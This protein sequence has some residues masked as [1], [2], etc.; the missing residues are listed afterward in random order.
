MTSQDVI[1]LR[2]A[3]QLYGIPGAA[4]IEN[5]DDYRGD[6][7]DD[8]QHELD[9]E[10]LGAEAG[11]G[12]SLLQRYNCL[13]SQHWLCK[14]PDAPISLKGDDGLD[15]CIGWSGD[16]LIDY[17]G[18]VALGI[19][20]FAEDAF[21]ADEDGLEGDD[22]FYRLAADALVNGIPQTELIALGWD[23][24]KAVKKAVRTVSKPLGKVVRTVTRPVTKVA[25]VVTKPVSRVVKTVTKP[26]A[27][28]VGKVT[29]KVLPKSIRNLGNAVI[30]SAIATTNPAN[31]LNPAKVMRDQIAVAKAAVPVA[32]QL[33][34]SPIVKTVAGGAAIVFP[35]VGVPAAA[36]LATASAI[37][38]AVDSKAP[39]VR[40]AAEKVL[41][42][43][44]KVI[45]GGKGAPPNSKAA[46]DAKGAEVAMAQIAQA[47]KAQM[48]TRISTPS[49]P[50]ARRLIHEV[51]P[52]GR[53]TRIVA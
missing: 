20:I 22:D 12:S 23:P 35:P 3:M 15:G 25:G 5:L 50:G 4:S 41:A 44:M 7:Q 49:T 31:M 26:V 40:A 16:D 52:N 2:E 8:T 10:L 46:Q 1:E 27:K 17:M 18:A 13:C 9:R 33:V 43:T 24:L 29:S 28:A 30:R 11:L 38:K 36:A 51:L 34:K 53:I 42:N 21:G 32:K 37:A 48:L 45:E 19:D 39:G 6:G 47:K 14:H